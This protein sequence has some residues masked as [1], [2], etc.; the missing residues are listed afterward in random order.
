MIIIVRSNQTTENN[1]RSAKKKKERE[2]ENMIL[3]YHAEYCFWGS[4]IVNMRSGR[5]VR[6]AG[7]IG[8][9]HRQSFEGW[10][11]QA[12]IVI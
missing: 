5:F 6:M 11:G 8:L 10:V 3:Q 7:C 2:R 4:A 1:N 9:R 12:Q